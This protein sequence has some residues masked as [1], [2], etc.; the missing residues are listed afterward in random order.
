MY[1]NQSETQSRSSIKRKM[2][3]FAYETGLIRAGRGIWAK[4]LTVVNYHRIDDPYQEGFDSF[5]PN[6]SAT[7][8]DFDRQLDYLAKWFNVVS[9]QDVVEWLDGHKD[10]PPYAALITFD[11]GYL[12]NYTSAFPLLQKQNFPALIFLTTGHIGTDAPFYWD[13]A[14]YCFAHTQSDHLTFPDGR[15]AHWSNSEQRE[16]VSKDWIEL[17]K[18]LPQVEKQI[19]VDNLPVLLGVS[20]PS[21]FFRGLMM[22]WDQVREM[23]KGGIEFGAHTI[24]HPILTRIALEQVRNEVAGSRSRIEDELGETV[25][26]FAYP[27]GQAM[28]LDEEVEKVVA[29]AGIRTA[30]TLL[31]GPSPQREVKRNPYA[32]RRIFISHKHSLAEYAMLLSPINRYRSG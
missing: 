26:G 27:N 25:L 3:N 6:I 20:I 32:I 12:D 13:M 22:N 1:S 30:F 15:I 24:H 2:L 11:D 18:T 19:Y 10:L 9:L 16:Q 31:N 23:Q 29:D 7:P 21:G 14:A 17:M 28:D 8:Q 4:S 5:K